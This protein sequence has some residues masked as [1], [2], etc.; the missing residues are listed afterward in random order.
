M[1]DIAIELR[2]VSKHYGGIAALKSVN[3]A[4]YTGEVGAL[5]G[6]NGAGKSTLVGVMSGAVKPD[7][8]EVRVQGRA[9]ASGSI[10][11]S[12]RA[13][14]ATVEQ[15]LHL[16]R[17]LP[18]SD[19]L[20]A[21][22]LP[23]GTAG[24]LP[25]K[26]RRQAAATTARRVSLS[27]D[28]RLPVGALSLAD[29]Q[30]VAIGRAL[31][32]GGTALL[33]DE[34]NSA[35]SIAESEAL[36][37]VMREL[38]DH[39]T[40]VVLISH[41]LDEVFAIADRIT[42]LRDGEVA[43][44]WSKD[45]WHRETVVRAM[46]GAAGDSLTPVAD[47]RAERTRPS[48]AGTRTPVI[49]VSGM[50]SRYL[51][52]VSLTLREGEILGVT[53]LE[54]SGAAEVLRGLAGVTK[55][56]GR[57][58]VRGKPYRPRHP[59]DAIRRGIVYLPPDRRTSG[60]WL[61]RTCEWNLWVGSLARHGRGETLLRRRKLRDRAKD[62]LARVGVRQSALGL[63][64]GSLSG[65]NQQR[66][67]LARALEVQ[68]QVLLLEEPTRGVDISARVEI[69]GLIQSVADGGNAVVISSPDVDEIL[70]VADRVICLSRG[71]QILDSG[72]KSIDRH[73]LLAKIAAG[74]NETV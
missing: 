39:G 61:K 65:G 73:E 12:R 43:G 70:A 3:V 2:G 21:G 41:R 34:P 59:A 18:V 32:S 27:A 26:R 33:L 30:R 16:F 7:T 67:M 56:Q 11:A 9:I 72:A 52:D 23:T 55:V 5:V 58:A 25:Q 24:W 50:S 48:G 57:L 44:S 54:G 19:N 46:V 49:E 66:L 6:A 15:E 53:G 47:R 42:V 68:G 28:L 1:D 62:G 69:F 10:A 45:E 40:A 74:G 14:I 60:L 20:V 71:V 63:A 22:D 8:G 37:D 36:F 13:G 51:K 64:A 29:Q 4:F 31:R 17:A 38:R 35:L